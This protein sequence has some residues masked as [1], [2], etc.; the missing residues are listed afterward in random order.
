MIHDPTETKHRAR[1][2]FDSWADSYD[3]SLL[4]YFLFRPCYYAF[5]EEIAR[6]QVANKAAPT[7][8]DIGCGTGTL[9]ALLA[10]SNLEIRHF[11]GLDYALQMC[12]RA[13]EK[14][15][16]V[17]ASGANRFV[18]AD[19]EHLPFRDQS[20]DIVTCANSFHHYPHQQT[21]VNQMR[22]I[23]K[24]GGQLMI[25]DGFRDNVI[26]WVV[27]DVVIT[28]IEQTVYHAPWHVMRDYMRSAGFDSIR[29]RKF[30]FLFPVL[31]T[32]ARIGTA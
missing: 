6:W 28:R 9:G 21:V 11:V 19:S 13:A 20:F 2:S 4:N 27:F 7:V 23:L 25:A 30:N 24:P 29:Q 14:A 8:L 22:R 3:R 5:I 16:R 10:N 15:P 31:L 26:G 1:T 12:Q 17:S 32:I 18:N